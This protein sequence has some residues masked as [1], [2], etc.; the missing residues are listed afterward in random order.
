ME[1][2][3]IH[4][5]IYPKVAGITKGVPMT[6]LELGQVKTGNEV[7]QFL[8]PSFGYTCSTPE[9]LLAY[10]DWC[11][12]S[13]AV[14][15]PN[16]LYGYHNDYFMEAVEKYPDRFCGVAL[17][18]LLKGEQAAKELAEIYENTPLFGFKVETDSTFQCAPHKHMADREFYPVWDCCAQHR[19]PVFLHLFT[20]KDV[21]DLETLVRDFPKITWV[22]CHMGADSCF[23]PGRHPGNYERILSL[24][25]KNDNI[26]LDTS[27]VPVYFLEEYP[28]PSSVKVIERAYHAVGSG[29]IM[30]SSD[31][32]GMLNHATMRE[33]M[34]LVLKYCKFSEE[35]LKEIMGGSAKRL[36]FEG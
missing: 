2:I 17:V 31:Y 5:H 27:T 33:L 8:P 35:D 22:I 26:Y 4:A 23:A 14:L 24:T 18:D 20:D 29:K 28:F 10:M 3:D 36:F 21:E 11:G 34:N 7:T 30:W 16:P 13:K 9:T 6:S 25:A 15:M 19:Q 32:P 1:I 12:I